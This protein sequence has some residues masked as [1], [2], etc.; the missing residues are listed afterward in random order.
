MLLDLGNHLV[1]IVYVVHSHSAFFGFLNGLK[2]GKLMIMNWENAKT[3]HKIHS[4]IRH[5][6]FKLE[7]ILPILRAPNHIPNH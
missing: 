1:Q 7:W 6:I 2:G 5:I 3:D 4:V